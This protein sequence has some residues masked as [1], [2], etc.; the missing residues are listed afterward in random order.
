[1]WFIQHYILLTRDSLPLLYELKKELDFDEKRL[2]QII[3]H[4]HVVKSNLRQ[5][6]M[7]LNY[8]IYE[9]CLN[10]TVVVSEWEVVG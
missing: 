9:T 3:E 10:K 7:K 4:K 6:K 2:K 8:M 5:L 1:M